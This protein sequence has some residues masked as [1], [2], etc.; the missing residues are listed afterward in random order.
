M[1]VGVM[2]RE[3]ADLELLDTEVWIDSTL[4][5]RVW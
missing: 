1:L 2:F 3:E 5:V 4:R